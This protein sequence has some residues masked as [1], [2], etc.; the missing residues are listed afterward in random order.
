MLKCVVNRDIIDFS[1]LPDR[2]AVRAFYTGRGITPRRAEFISANY[3]L[4]VRML[5]QIVGE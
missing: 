1:K 2:P 5:K 4:K 3:E